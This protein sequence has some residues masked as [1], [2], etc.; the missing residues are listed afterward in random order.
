MNKYNKSS[1]R[2]FFLQGGAVLGT[3]MTT[4]AGAA[5]LLPASAP[6]HVDELRRLQLQLA[7]IADREA[8][9]NLQRA[10]TSLIAERRYAVVAELF[11]EDARLRLSGAEAVGKRAI[12]RLFDEQYRAQQA[13]VLHTAF[14]KS[15]RHAADEVQLAESRLEA[16][17]TF[18]VDAELSVPLQ[19][20]CTAAKM[21]RLQG[22][23]ASC[24]WESGRLEGRYV[25]NER[26]VI[27]ALA[28]AV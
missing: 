5:A 1:R 8:I 18:H 3:G 10:F 16:S 12:H 17:A 15:P 19:N 23:M 26:W 20:N 13:S 25:K 2:T 11:A 6:A 22:Q 9:Q 4:A 27:A 14:R 7:D 28:Y 24:H 21:A